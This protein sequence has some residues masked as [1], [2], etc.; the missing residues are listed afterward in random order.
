MKDLELFNENCKAGY[1]NTKSKV[2]WK[3]VDDRLHLQGSVETE[4]WW[5]NFTVWPIPYRIRGVWCWISLGML[6]AWLDIRKQV[7]ASGARE[8]VMY[9]GGCPVGALWSAETGLP[10]V[11]FGSPNFL[12][13]PTLKAKALFSEVRFVDAPFDI[14]TIIPPGAERGDRVYDLDMR[15]VEKPDPCPPLLWVT[16]HSTDEYRQRLA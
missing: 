1:Q 4:D 16:G 12:W 7:L 2:S 10:A 14:V 15:H 13:R 5:R 9:S 8:A 3:M 6:C 11:G